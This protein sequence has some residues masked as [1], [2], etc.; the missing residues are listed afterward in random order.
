MVADI[1]RQASS[2]DLHFTEDSAII[3][4]EKSIESP[5][6]LIGIKSSSTTKKVRF[7]TIEVRQYAVILGDYQSC[8]YPICLDW[9][10]TKSYILIIDDYDMK[11]SSA[12]RPLNVEER[13]ERLQAMG[14]RKIDLRTKERD[15]RINILR[16][17]ECKV[18]DDE[19][20]PP[21]LF[22]LDF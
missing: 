5:N 21:P 22:T 6:I 16:D 10:H 14:F 7:S 1:S 13:L 4:L 9:G 3:E 20:I 17:W 11:I 18:D 8:S 12:P 19:I 15:R 2:H